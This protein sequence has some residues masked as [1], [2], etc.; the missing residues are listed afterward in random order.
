VTGNSIVIENLN[1]DN[2][3]VIHNESQS[4]LNK[5]ILQ[6]IKKDNLLKRVNLL[7]LDNI[8][9]FGKDILKELRKKSVKYCYY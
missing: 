9:K 3:G 2:P 1:S 4:Q 7:L 6:A 5:N 8:K